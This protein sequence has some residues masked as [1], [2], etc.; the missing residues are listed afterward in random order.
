V[1]LLHGFPDSSYLW[2]HQIP[3]LVDGGYRV[4][5]PDLRGFGE[6][7]KPD[8]VEA[9]ALPV[10]ATDTVALLDALEAPRAHVVGHDWGA[11]LSWLLVTLFPD[12]FEKHAALS[13]G[14]FSAFADAP[15]EQR[16]KSWYMLLF[17]FTGI[18]EQLLTRDDWKLFREF[19]RNH[20]ELDQWTADLARPGALTA[21]LN[22]YRANVNPRDMVADPPSLPSVRVPTLGV[23]STGDAYL[24]EA[25]M[26]GSEQYVSAP[27]RYERV[28]DASHWMQLDQPTRVNKLLLEFFKG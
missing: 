21:A 18:A 6:S 25:A 17:Q 27:W 8:A 3:A 9:Y 20:S 24:T 11:A 10:I 4:I 2:R 16:E 26:A 13:V 7:D 23:W 19:T 14:H 28:E 15:L 5:A 1:L 12:R 22:W